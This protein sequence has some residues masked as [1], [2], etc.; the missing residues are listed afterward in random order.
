MGRSGLWMAAFALLFV[1][2]GALDLL[3]GE[4][5][6]GSGL[7]VCGLGSA[8]FAVGDRGDDGTSAGRPWRVLGGTVS[9]VG[10]G[11]LA[12]AVFGGG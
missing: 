5:L 9:L 2:L 1:V 4:P 3:G 8:L 7:L 6:T 11:L 10:I 12:M